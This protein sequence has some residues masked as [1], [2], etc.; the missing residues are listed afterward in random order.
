MK[1]KI[2]ILLS[3]ML[4]QAGA[5]MAEDQLAFPGAKGWGRFATGGRSGSVYHV[6][7]LNDS[8]T[9]SLRDAV[10]SPNRI[11]VFDVS[12]VINIS[13]RIVFEN[14]L[15]VAGQTAPGEGI[16]VYGDGVSFS[17]ADNIIVRHI[18][19][20][21]GKNGTSGKD[22]AGIANGQNMIFD[23]CSFS[24]GL[25]E[26]F[27]INPD[28]KGSDPMYITISNCIIG[29]GLLTHSAG[30][31]IQSDSITLY[32]NFYVDNDTRNNKVK[33][34]SQYVNNIVYN[35]KDGCYLMGGD[36]SGSSY[37][38]VT[39]NLFINGPSGTG[40]AITS[41]NSD[42]HIY[43][44][45]NW[46]DRDQDG[47]LDPYEIPE[48]E[49]SGGPTFADEPYDYPELPAWDATSLVDSLLPEVGA[50][51]PYRDQ[52]DFL[53]VHQCKSFGTEGGLISS[54]SQLS[55]GTP[56]DWG[57]TSFDAPT[58]T[59]GDG[60]P[61]EW[62][63][64][65]GTDPSTDDA[66]TIASNGYANIENYINSL[67][68]D[69]R[70]IFLRD[71]ILVEAS[72]S[73]PESITIGW[74]DF[75]EGEDGFY[76]EQLVDDDTYEVVG[77]AD[78]D[79]ETFTVDSLEAGTAYSFRM[80][81]FKGTEY[82]SNYVYL[83]A[84][85]KP[86]Q[87]DMVDCDTFEGDDTDNWLI[88]TD[89]EL[90]VTIDESVEKTAIVVRG[91][92][93]VTI[94]G[95]GS[96]DGSASLN[97]AGSGTLT[98]ETT[99]GY[100]GQTVLHDGTF[101]FSS[102]ADGGEESSIGASYEYSQNWIWDG[103]VWE[104]TGS[105]TSTNRCAML[106]DDTEFNIASSAS[107]TMNGYIEGDGD[108]IISGS[109]TVVPASQ[110]FFQFNGNTVLKDGGTLLLSYINSL[111]SLEVYMDSED[112]TS[113]SLVL[114]GGNFTVSNAG[115]SYPSY[116]FPIEVEEGTYST[117]TVGKNSYI[118]CKVSGTGTL[119]YQIPYVREYISGDW[120]EFYG[121]LVANGV[122][123]DSDG[124][125]LMLQSGFAGMPNAQ[126]YLTG[127]TRMLGWA[128][129]AEMTIGGISGD[130]GTYLSAT[131]KNTTAATMVWY[132]GGANTDETF[133][134][135]IDNLTSAGKT[136]T[137]SIVKEGSA[138]WRLTGTNTYSGTT[139]VNGGSLIVNGTNSG[140]GAVTVNENGTL[141]GTGTIAG[142]VTVESGGIIQAGDTI[143]G[144][145]SLKLSS[146]LKVKSGGIV[147][148]PVSGK[149]YN[150]IKPSG[151]ITLY[152]GS[153]LQINDG[154]LDEAPASGTEYTVFFL[155]ELSGEFSYI[156]PETPGDSLEWDTSDLYT[157]G[158]LRVKS[159]GEDDSDDETSDGDDEEEE[160]EIQ[161]ALL[162][163]GNMYTSSYDDSGVNNMLI[164]SEGDTAEGF[165]LVLS[166]NLAKAY[167]SAQ[168]I[169]LTYLGE[170]I[171]RTTIKCSNGAENS[172]YL[173]SGAVAT[174][175]TLWSYTNLDEANRT[176]YWA[177]VGGVDYDEETGTILTCYKDYDNPDCVSF[178]LDDLE[179][180]VTFRNTGEQQC[181][182]IYLEYYY[183]S[184]TGISLSG[185]DST[186]VSVEYYTLS[187]MKI[188]NPSGGLY[189]MKVKMADGRV[190]S[191]K[192]VL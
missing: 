99:N 7:N 4:F 105:S 174:N 107:V 15:Y 79:T 26:V 134:G 153:I 61:D 155:S 167:T 1:L 35:W 150:Y 159:V 68:K 116:L 84:K 168:K 176:N 131:S 101:S 20:R 52:A 183:P 163:W 22:C 75:T 33:G 53:M 190:Y 18:R 98:V 154:V 135:V 123:S 100:T 37:V 179:E 145:K 46:Q 6:T 92:G 40:N 45:D 156:Y 47:I 64:A 34:T 88:E 192:V 31:L 39:N 81:A 137:T 133:K 130:A 32:R 126:V 27:S 44:L 111:E 184:T 185:Q 121:T 178:D 83:D 96:L 11:V 86:E 72:A 141:K 162:C 73:T 78:A 50:S 147:N 60:M 42:F 125:Q 120:S 166:G 82:Y 158:I 103:G 138:D 87:V 36:S 51:L 17:G 63:S 139:E 10:S 93:D 189:I 117:F 118:K 91:T 57:V 58:D 188:E 59:D 164:G 29:Q 48:S 127:N 16:I 115:G 160:V 21:M 106:Y 55:I 90:T 71:P 124:S 175:I 94:T 24:W 144:S 49:Y 112:D 74:Y 114:A 30:G 102:L 66:M 89:D 149:K 104:Y 108:L 70:T 148:V 129:N 142:A 119:E 56:D 14:N 3:L 187:G 97:K 9:G 143:I 80:R 85:T 54:E 165:S 77:T 182:V 191:S 28:N 180:V 67:S 128:T 13:S 5:I 157:E 41:G 109:G 110:E 140:T 151:K 76:I 146:T 169:T 161:T 95:S 173:P 186:P 8:G 19:F 43:A 113:K 69:N 171:S 65:N 25:D 62:E 23:H 12:G 38:N 132:V 136:A 181:V 177:S 2:Y 122:G 152:D 170:E 172:L